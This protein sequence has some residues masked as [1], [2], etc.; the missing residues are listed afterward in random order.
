[1]LLSLTGKVTSLVAKKDLARKIE[2]A[3]SKSNLWRKGLTFENQEI[4]LQR[5]G[6]QIIWSVPPNPRIL[7]SMLRGLGG[8]IHLQVTENQ[9]CEVDCGPYCTV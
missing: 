1:M 6:N 4:L 2:E 8:K 5:R 3:L 9:V 7:N